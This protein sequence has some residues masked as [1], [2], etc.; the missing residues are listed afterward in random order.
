MRVR[1][2]A[3][4][5]FSENDIPEGQPVAT[6]E[7]VLVP[8]YLLHRYQL[9]AAAK[10]L[11]GLYYTYAVR[12]D[13]QKITE[14][15]PADQQRKALDALLNTLEPSVLEIPESILKLIPPQPPGYDRTRENFVSNTGLTFDPLSAAATAAELTVRLILQPQRDARLIEYNSRDSS[16]PSLSEV[17]DKLVSATILSQHNDKKREEIQEVIDNIVLNHLMSLA[18]AKGT[19]DEVNAIALFKLKN[20]KEDLTEKIKA[21]KNE[22]LL[23]HYEYLISKINNFENNPDSIKEIKTPDIPEGQPIGSDNDFDMPLIY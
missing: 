12:G 6:L 2:I 1:K 19:I 4:D 17:I 23:A 15:V 22:N 11:G 21:T 5:N 9:E 10:S 13:G 3:L 20:L 18:R 14:I 8:I 16:C 7:N